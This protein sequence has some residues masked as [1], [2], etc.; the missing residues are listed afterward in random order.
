MER[1]QPWQTPHLGGFA[2]RANRWSWEWIDVLSVSLVTWSTLGSVIDRLR[3]R[4]FQT[5]TVFPIF[6]FNTANGDFSDYWS[7]ASHCMLQPWET[8]LRPSDSGTVVHRHNLSFEIGWHILNLVKIR[9]PEAI[10]NTLLLHSSR[11]KSVSTA[12]GWN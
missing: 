10:G 7:Y 9:K 5:A 2:Q 3:L 12:S 1:T 8:S 4:L 6:P 11:D